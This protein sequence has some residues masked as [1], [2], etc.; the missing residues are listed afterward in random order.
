MSDDETVTN[1]H[2]LPRTVTPRHYSIFIHPHLDEHRFEGTVEIEAEVPEAVE[3]IV[4]HSSGLEITAATVNG[5]S[6]TF[7]LD[8]ANDQMTLNSAPSTGSATIEISFNGQFNE[9]LVGFYLSNFSDDNG[10]EH[11]MATT[12]FEAPYARMAFPCWDEPEYKATFEISLHVPAGLDAVSNARELRR[13]KNGDGTEIVHFAPTM[14]MSTYLVAWVIGPLEFSETRMVNDVPLRVVSRPGLGTMST[15]ALDAA[16]FALAYFADYFGVPYPGDKVDLIG[17]PDFAFGAMENLGCITFREA[18]LMV[19]PA[20]TTQTEMQRSVDVVNHELAHMWFGDLV[21]MSWW[22]GIWLNE[23]FATFMEMK[24]TDAFKP[25]W[26]RWADFGLSRSAA[27]STDAL[28]S[29][30]PIEFTVNTPEE[31]EGMFDI[32]TYEKGAAV[33]RMLEIHLGE[34]VFRSALR[35]YM[36]DNAYGNTETT[37]LWDAIEEKS[38]QPVREMMDG[39]IFQGGFPLVTVK[40]KNNMVTLSQSRFLNAGS[41]PTDPATV[42]PVWHTPLRFRMGSDDN[43]TDGSIVLG[44]EPVE[45]DLAGNRWIV[46]NA[47]GASF[48][49]V[50]Y[51]PDMLDALSSLSPGQLSDVER[52]GLIDDAW[53]SVLANRSSTTTFLTLLDSMAS[54]TERPVWLRI[55]AGLSHLDA[56]V[57]GDARDD[58]AAIAHDILS[59]MLANLGLTPVADEPEATRQLRADLVKAMGILAEDRDVQAECQRTVS[60]GRRDPSLV[61]P[62]LMAAAISVAAHVG[63]ETDFDDFAEMYRTSQ[64]PQEQLRY[65]YSLSAF[66]S[67]ELTA[68]LCQMVLA[69][70][71]RTQNAPFSLRFALENRFGG[72]YTWEFIKENWNQ[73]SEMFA[74]GSIGRMLEGLSALDTPEQVLDTATFIADHPVP[75]AEKQLQ[76]TLEKQRVNAMLRERESARLNAFVTQ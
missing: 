50:A 53:A 63:D 32:L 59:P 25:Q 64:N 46:V 10:V 35:S 65:L 29:T 56:L 70:R 8:E 18:I 54:E 34:D 27:F 26:N 9:K 36:A 19:D 48:V 44:A 69:G 61:D 55:I 1:P 37:D 11:Q 24:C 49:R 41:E 6:S 12:Q 75:Q 51:P 3:S 7:S 47:D 57:T 71:V 20:V 52:Y 30:R 28:A 2:R 13:T 73:L 21:T 15:F 17:I 31:S 38:G 42:N 22:N 43:V 58:F 76:Q 5:E 40:V 33:V 16:E 62:S 60:V 39:W 74:S 66:P 4:L 23:A 14:I 72:R 45:I 67:E 68:K